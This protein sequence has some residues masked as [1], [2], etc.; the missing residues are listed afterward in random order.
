MLVTVYFTVKAAKGGHFKIVEILLRIYDESIIN[1]KSRL[2]YSPLMGGKC[3]LN[4][5]YE[6]SSY[7][8]KYVFLASKFGHTKV[9]K[10]LID[11][12]A[13]VSQTASDGNTVLHKG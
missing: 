1:W 11:N 13:D 12:G 4:F 10:L 7:H 2:G 9:V 3:T 6:L 5:F 8:Y